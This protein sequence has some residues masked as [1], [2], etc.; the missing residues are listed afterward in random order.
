MSL[1]KVTVLDVG[2]GSST[3]LDLGKH[4]YGIVDCGGGPLRGASGGSPL[5]RFL[6]RARAANPHM[7]IAFI[8]ITH[9]DLD[10]IDAISEFASDPDLERRVERIYCN[11]LAYRRLL[12][13]VRAAVKPGMGIGLNPTSSAKLRALRYLGELVARRAAQEKDF[14]FEC[15]AP[16]ASDIN[17]YPVKLNLPSLPNVD[18]HIWA[19]SHQARHKAL[20]RI[21]QQSHELLSTLL[22]GREVDDW[23]TASVMLTVTAARRRV[24]IAGDATRN[25]WDDVLRRAGPTWVGADVVVAWHHG[26]KLG[27]GG[28]PHDGLVWERVLSRDGKIVCVSC[29]GHNRYGHPHPEMIGAAVRSGGHIFCTQRRGS[30]AITPISG[31]S[32]SAHVRVLRDIAKR[33]PWSS[34]LQCCGT[35]TVSIGLQGELETVCESTLCNDRIT[36]AGCCSHPQ[37]LWPP[38]ELRRPSRS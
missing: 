20:M 38:A 6:R 33:D 7:R 9:L 4:R 21:P 23:N 2:Q 27:D 29:G 5:F 26:A 36:I 24:L 31:G 10:H 37:S 13:A 35:I 30:R 1:L 34:G 19:P 28:T 14:H 15:I 17:R 3:V 8:L 22:S 18:I 25:T 12:V 16:E 32:G 11:D